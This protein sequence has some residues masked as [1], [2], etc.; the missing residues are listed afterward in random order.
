[1]D[2]RFRFRE[3]RLDYLHRLLQESGIS[4]ALG[5]R[6]D[7]EG[8]YRET[9]SLCSSMEELTGQLSPAVLHLPLAPDGML[10]QESLHA[11]TNAQSLGHLGVD[12]LSLDPT[13]EVP[14]QPASSHTYL[15]LPGTGDGAMQQVQSNLR[16]TFDEQ[17]YVAS[18]AQARAQSLA[19]QLAGEASSGTSAQSDV[20][21]ARPGHMLVVDEPP[22]GMYPRRQTFFV[23]GM[24]HTGADGA[25]HGVE[26][27]ASYSNELDLVPV[28]GQADAP[29]PVR[30]QGN[31]QVT[32]PIPMGIHSA[33]V[34]GADGQPGNGHAPNPHVDKAGRVL[35]AVHGIEHTA[36]ESKD[37]KG[38]W[39]RVS[40][41]WA[42]AKMGAFFW[43]RPGME[44]LL[45]FMGAHE[46]EPII[47]GSAYNGKNLPPYITE[48]A[49]Y[50]GFKTLS[51]GNELSFFDAP[52]REE[53]M[54]D[55]AR[56]LK[57]EAK[58]LMRTNVGLSNYFL[59][60]LALGRKMIA[61]FDDEAE[62]NPHL[63]LVKPKYHRLCNAIL[64]TAS[65]AA[66]AW[67]KGNLKSLSKIGIKDLAISEMKFR[68]Y[69]NALEQIVLPSFSLETL[70]YYKKW[71]GKG[72]VLFSAYKQLDG[73]INGRVVSFT[74][75]YGGAEAK[76][77]EGLK[78]DIEKTL[79]LEA[80]KA[81][82]VAAQEAALTADHRLTLQQTSHFDRTATITLEGGSTNI[83]AHEIHVKADEKVVI[84]AGVLSI[85]MHQSHI[86]IYA[87]KLDIKGQ[88]INITGT[89]S[90][91]LKS[92][93]TSI[94]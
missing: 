88:S 72:N 25:Q 31:L 33:T 75:I 90:I 37:I 52:G 78:L 26:A 29:S 3:N 42:G 86:E 82:K 73:F 23:T 43:P 56:T 61:V 91:T 28:G 85:T 19:H 93:K 83:S 50:S 24:R 51:S 15:T 89:D 92:P 40:H 32:Q 27:A 5:C 10:A 39:V 48:Q 62:A 47:L 64:S 35:V 67:Q 46:G 21:A 77:T 58:E 22:G 34:L 14:Q 9:I 8:G 54:L 60:F 81:V 69:H 17:H 7:G 70:Q 71:V 76:V 63:A 44:V 16:H 41:L 68:N 45:G 79:A 53:L 4:Y 13:L 49:E 66:E 94:Y 57:I 6:S 12:V 2:V 11:V 55:A 65:D 30:W 1:M 84:R 59:N 20:L 38:F 36:V 80:K 18:L 87:P 74:N